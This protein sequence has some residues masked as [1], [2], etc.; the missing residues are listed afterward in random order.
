MNTIIPLWLFWYW[1]IVPPSYAT[2][3]FLVT[4]VMAVR[5]R[6]GTAYDHEG[7]KA[8]DPEGN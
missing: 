1:L 8:D 2:A 6:K 5:Q 7:F 4:L 3:V